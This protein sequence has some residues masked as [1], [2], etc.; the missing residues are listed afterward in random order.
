[1]CVYFSIYMCGH[2]KKPESGEF[3]SQVWKMFCIR[4][5]LE[6]IKYRLPVWLNNE[7]VLLLIPICPIYHD[8]TDDLNQC[9]VCFIF[10]LLFLIMLSENINQTK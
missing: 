4:R 5:D 10:L 9:R 1:M 8:T 7:Y 3:Q 2:K 6:P